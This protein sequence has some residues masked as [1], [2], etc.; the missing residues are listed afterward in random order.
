MGAKPERRTHAEGVRQKCAEEDISAYEGG[1]NRG[2][3][4]TTY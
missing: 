4:K 2:V 3:E 1:N